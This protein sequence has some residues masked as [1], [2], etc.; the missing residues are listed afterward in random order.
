MESWHGDMKFE[1]TSIEQ[2]FTKTKI[3]G[4]AVLLKKSLNEVQNTGL[5]IIFV[6]HL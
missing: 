6:E 5:C 2:I 4:R 3:N 1:K